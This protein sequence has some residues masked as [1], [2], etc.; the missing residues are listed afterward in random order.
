MQLMIATPIRNGISLPLTLFLHQIHVRYEITV[1]LTSL[2]LWDVLSGFTPK[3]LH[4]PMISSGSPSKYWLGSTLTSMSKWETLISAW[5]DQKHV[6]RRMFILLCIYDLVYKKII[7]FNVQGHHIFLPCHFI[8]SRLS[9]YLTH[10]W[11]RIEA[12]IHFPRVFVKKW[13]QQTWL[14]FELGT[15]ISLSITDY[16][17]IQYCLE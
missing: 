11:G 15:V 7:I 13:L 17:H 10:S 2:H 4:Y 3:C 5:F 8:C 9:F 16:A 14:D 6:L 1:F 12:F